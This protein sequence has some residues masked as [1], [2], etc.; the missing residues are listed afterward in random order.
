MFSANAASIRGLAKLG[1]V[2]SDPKVEAMT[3]RIQ[4]AGLAPQ[5]TDVLAPLPS[6]R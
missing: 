4:A 6:W 2:L 5:S 1:Q 3:D